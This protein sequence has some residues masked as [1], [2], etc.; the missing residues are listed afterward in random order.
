MQAVA[1]Q[2]RVLD[3]RW[4]AAVAVAV[5]L[6][7]ALFVVGVATATSP[8]KA[9]LAGMGLAVGV[10]MLASPSFALLMVAAVI[11]LERVGRFTGDFDAQVIS[12]SRIS[13]LI[14]LGAL[15]L[16]GAIR[17]WKLRFGVAFWMYAAYA[18]LGALSVAYAESPRDA[19]RDEMRILG[20]LLFLFLVINLVREFRLAKAAILIW[21][22][23]NTAA[24]IYSIYGYHFGAEAIEESE[25]G[26][27]DQ[28]DKTVMTDGSDF[29]GIGQVVKR[30][31][32][33]TSHPTLFGLNLVLSLPFYGWMIRNAAWRGRLFG[34]LGV[35]VSCYGV[36]ICNT[37]A[38]LLLGAGVLL[39]TL[40]R[41][42]WALTPRTILA[43]IVGG[44]LLVPF[45]PEHVWM[46]A[47][48]PSMY[49]AKNSDSIRIRFKYWEKS[50]EIFQDHW[51]YG[52]GVGN[53]TAIVKAVTD[54][55]A[56]R[57]TSDGK[58]A[59]AH[60]EYLQTLVEVGLFGWLLQFGFVA[61]VIYYSFRA[62]TL[63]RPF[64]ETQE[65]YWLMVACQAALISV[66][67]F[68][69]QVDALHFGIKGWWLAAGLACGM[70]R[71]AL[72]RVQQERQ[73]VWQAAEN[74]LA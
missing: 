36:I 38:L 12:L 43:V 22:A 7:G 60:N 71:L 74:K 49:T 41:G 15:L 29:R 55:E 66:A 25:V 32:G 20:N 27:T 70:M 44:A 10:G 48:D 51:W 21:L 65:H 31:I 13:G 18:A 63:F 23:V 28:R 16:H 39:Y 57:D 67:V 64:R 52:I 68:A 14:A 45:V 5:G 8:L 6:G 11:P 17:R 61:L 33:T 24:G 54:E 30:A 26:L 50:W 35:L 69:I 2:P 62:A 4:T 9:M 42:L 34:L 56:G 1:Q 47:L 37:R 72:E 53:Q 59:S 3:R 19:A 58:K 73:G 46:R 40:M